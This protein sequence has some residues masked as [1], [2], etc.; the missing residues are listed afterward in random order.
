MGTI[1]V[2]CVLLLVE[3][4]LGQHAEMCFVSRW[5]F[6]EVLFG[7]MGIK[8]STFSDLMT[9]L[10]LRRSGEKNPLCPLHC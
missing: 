2:N 3:R 8:A 4:G 5:D 1:A 6:T 9:S 7:G 10:V